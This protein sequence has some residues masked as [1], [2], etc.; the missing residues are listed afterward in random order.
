MKEKVNFD[1]RWG[2]EHGIG[3]FA[4]EIEKRNPDFIRIN[5]RI[6]PSSPADIFFTT[7]YV[8]FHSGIYFSP[9]YNAPLFFLKKTILT[10]HDLNHIDVDHNTSFLK[11]IYYRFV[12]K[13]ACRKSC[14]IF[15]VSEFSKK[16]ICEWAD[17]PSSQVDVVGNG[18][19]AEFHSNIEPHEGNY[20]LVVGNRK[21]HKNELRALEAFSNANLAKDINLYFTGEQSEELDS[22]IKNQHLQDRV[23]FMGRLDN[24]KLAS[25]YKG[26]RMLL[27]PSLYEGFG[28]PVIEA[29]ACGTPVIT[30]NTTSLPEVSGDAAILVNPLNV[31]E[32][33]EAIE[34]LN[35]NPE[36][37]NKLVEKGLERAKMFS[38]EN[39][40]ERIKNGLEDSIYRSSD[41]KGR[42]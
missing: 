23:F 21:R 36:L 7:L 22:Y 35:C 40:V 9:G 32:I 14:K 20:I 26:A 24:N 42:L 2:G 1:S 19:S 5:S 33:K 18:V 34:S 25:L 8:A 39:T 17:I 37:C 15:T 12:L 11:K 30:S 3:R 41:I 16:R 6:K 4:R 28:L 10:V 31:D 29:M 13:R 27:F 38:W